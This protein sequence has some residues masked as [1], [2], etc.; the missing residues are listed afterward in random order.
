MQA[1]PRNWQEYHAG[2]EAEL[3]RQRHFSYSDRIRYYWPSPQAEQAVS[4]LRQRLE[5]RQIP[6]PIFSH[7]LPRL[8]GSRSFDDILIASVQETLRRYEHACTPGPRLDDNP[9]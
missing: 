2:S 6:E 3:W 5:G 9:G 8:V 7:Y 4:R 1:S